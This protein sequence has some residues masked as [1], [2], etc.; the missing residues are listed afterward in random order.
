MQL[1]TAGVD[2]NHKVLFEPI[3]I[4]PVTAP[5]RFY[6]TPYATGFG[7]RDPAAGARFREIR[8]EG[9]WG[10]VSTEQTEIHPS[11][12]MTPYIEGRLWDD[13]HIA[14]LALS[15]DAIHRH[16]SL[17]ALELSHCG[18]NIMNAI[19]REDVLG[20]SSLP[21][22]LTFPTLPEPS[23]CRA[24]SLADIGEVRAW[25]AQAV[26][27][28]IA[29]GFDI[30]YVY[31]SLV[32]SLPA[33]FLS[34]RYNKRTD[35]Y[36]GSLINRVRLLRELIEDTLDAVQ[37]RCAVATRVTL[38]ELLES[39]L[40]GRCEL[41]EFFSIVGELPDLWDVVVG[42][43]GNDAGSAQFG[44]GALS[45][46]VVRRVKGLTTKPVVSVG[47]FTSPDTMAD[48]VRDGVLDLIGAARPSIADPFLPRKVAEGRADGIVKC[49]ACN[50]CVA[51]DF[52]SA[53]IRCPQNP[54]AGE[55]LRRNWHPVHIPRA[56]SPQ[57]CLVVGAGVAGLECAR[58]LS[59]AGCAVTLCEGKDHVGGRVILESMLPGIGQW[60]DVVLWRQA[61][62]AEQL[63]ASIA[64]GRRVDADMAL[65]GAHD[66]IILATGARWRADGVGHACHFPVPADSDAAPLTPDDVF[67]R[68]RDKGAK[69]P[70]HVTI[71]DDEHYY[72]AS[73]IADYLVSRQVAVTF[74]TPAAEVA[75]WS[76]KTMEQFFL[77]SRLMRNGVEII[78]HHRLARIGK[79]VS[80]FEN[81]FVGTARSI[82]H[83]AIIL[84]TA[85]EP[86]RA[87]HDELAKIR[88]NARLTLIGDASAPGT[89]T[90]VTY[91]AHRAAR[92]IIEGR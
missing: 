34:T 75:I 46:E 86:D 14:D 77:Q 31:A 39:P 2:P 88:P 28:G 18:L 1:R 60:R 84:V 65:S 44:G 24:M 57:R 40:D 3:R 51:S 92:A 59:A 42:G 29:A 61:A 80:R 21:L 70:E 4:G 12:D 8:A 56:A 37:G 43:Y 5:N 41:E 73:L 20:P 67:L 22:T 74:V 49:V 33:Q 45:A 78:P 47:C 87:L 53:P 82:G 58:L 6:Q 16:G 83:D 10:V 17:A 64:M 85:R 38:D 32:L 71:Y 19:T 25:H 7:F 30:I 15:A 55:E 62:L 68:M 76:H 79:G 69:W 26:R 50:L 72:T 23:Q 36:G 48:L 89:L 90:H 11:S 9:G 52:S 91:S 13:S 54:T 63:E 81:V 27:R 35:R 66:H